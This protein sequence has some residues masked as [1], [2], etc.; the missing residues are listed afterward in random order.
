MGYKQRNPNELH[1][2]IYK[3]HV[4]SVDP[5]YLVVDVSQI[6]KQFATEVKVLEFVKHLDAAFSLL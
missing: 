3:G 2:K 6:S 1:R 4:V 5:N